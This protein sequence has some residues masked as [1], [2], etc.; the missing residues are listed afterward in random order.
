MDNKDKQLQWEKLNE[1]TLLETRIFSISEADFRG[2]KGETHHFSLMNAPNW[3]NVIALV[4]SGTDTKILMVRQYRFG[5]DQIALEFPGGV[6]DPG[7]E[8]LE[9]AKRELQE[10]TG[11]ASAHWRKLGE[12][13]PNP[14]FMTNTTS[15]YLARDCQQ[16]HEQNL[17]E[18]EHL[19]VELIAINELL[20]G[21]REDFYVNAIMLVSLH[22]FLL[23]QKLITYYPPAP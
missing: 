19:A 17:D 1:K 5:S 7:E 6:V 22:W 14:A 8:I 21:K 10:E 3:V 16:L 4:G 2:P 20:Q 18:H 15:T 23:D 11:Y 9:A 12:I 13:C